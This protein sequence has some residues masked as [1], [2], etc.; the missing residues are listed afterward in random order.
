MLLDVV[1]PVFLNNKII[2]IEEDSL[3]LFSELHF[4]KNECEESPL[5]SCEAK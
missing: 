1:I 4:K 3:S 5:S 2:T